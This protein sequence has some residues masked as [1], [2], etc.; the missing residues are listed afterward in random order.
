MRVHK[1]ILAY[2]ARVCVSALYIYTRELLN[3]YI[4]PIP[5]TRARSIAGTTDAECTLDRGCSARTVCPT[6]RHRAGNEHYAQNYA[7]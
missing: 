3:Q 5:V 2:N 4:K 6:R 1:D 7:D